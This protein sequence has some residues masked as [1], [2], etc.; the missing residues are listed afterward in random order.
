MKNVS[1]VQACKDFY[2]TEIV[3]QVYI[4]RVGQCLFGSS[5]EIKAKQ[6]LMNLLDDINENP[7]IKVVLIIAEQTIQSVHHYI[8][9]CDT[10]QCEDNFGIQFYRFQN[11]ISDITTKIAHL[12]KFVIY[13]DHRKE[14]PLFLNLAFACDFRIFQTGFNFYNPYLDLNLAPRGGEVFFI[15]RLLG[16]KKTMDLFLSGKNCMAEDAL[17]VG[18]VDEVAA[19]EELEKTALAHAQAFASKP[20]YLVGAVKR[21]LKSS[22]KNLDD[23]LDIERE[24]HLHL[25]NNG[26]FNSIECQL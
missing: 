17:R 23:C 13:T 7:K 26:C 16:Y 15:S 12:D 18:L 3:D 11:A 10:E 21:L 6:K 24:M 5:V 20:P 25:R 19:K 1:D 9:L 2:T 8:K 14:I 4:F 22:L